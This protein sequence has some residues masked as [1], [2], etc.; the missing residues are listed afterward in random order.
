MPTRFTACELIEEQ[1]HQL[2]ARRD[3]GCSSMNAGKR[4]GQGTWENYERK[5][6][7]AAQAC[8]KVLKISLTSFR[9]DLEEIIERDTRGCVH[10]IPFQAGMLSIDIDI[11]ARFK[12]QNSPS[13]EDLC[14]DDKQVV[15]QVAAILDDHY[16]SDGCWKSLSR[17][18]LNFPPLR[19]LRELKDTIDALT[20]IVRTPGEA[21]RAQVFFFGRPL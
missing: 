3:H 19:L 8:L 16:V 2:T 17:Y 12:G 15:R 20:E 9:L 13:F 1:V 21:R 4:V 11:K 5:L 10:G 14:P 18:L 7:S 6:I